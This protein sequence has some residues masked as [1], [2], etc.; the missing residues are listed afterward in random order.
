MLLEE[1][2]APPD[3]A[4]EEGPKATMIPIQVDQ[5]EEAERTNLVAVRA[6]SL[7][8]VAAERTN[9]AH[10]VAVHTGLAAEAAWP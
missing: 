3:P 4:Q 9:L 2:K 5:L 10:Q 6:R 8:A 1:Q 7:P